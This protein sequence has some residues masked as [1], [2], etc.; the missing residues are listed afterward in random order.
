M[1]EKISNQKYNTID[2][3]S[4]KEVIERGR[5]LDQAVGKKVLEATKEQKLEIE[6]NEK[7]SVDEIAKIYAPCKVFPGSNPNKVNVSLYGKYMP[8]MTVVMPTKWDKHVKGD[9]YVESKDVTLESPLKYR[10]IP[11]ITDSLGIDYNAKVDGVVPVKFWKSKAG[12]PC[13]EVLQG[14]DI[15]KTTHMLIKAH[16]EKRFGYGNEYLD[17]KYGTFD[18]IGYAAGWSGKITPEWKEKG[19]KS[20]MERAGLSYFHHASSNG[21]AVGSDYYVVPVD[22]HAEEWDGKPHHKDNELAIERRQKLRQAYEAEREKFRG[23]VLTKMERERKSAEGMEKY[24]PVFEEL[25]ERLNS[26]L[27]EYNKEAEA[28]GWSRMAAMEMGIENSQAKLH[29]E[30]YAFDENG[31][32]ELTERV[33]DIVDYIDELRKENSG[34]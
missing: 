15:N 25:Q 26:T 27:L 32:K 16:Y 11:E 29:R 17:E 9:E 24:M 22:Y 21:G 34:L 12:K 31:M 7:L 23:K 6:E 2:D 33:N 19:K 13:C 4:E 20:P 18:E 3:A 30:Y 14:D 5:K 1:S 8:N 28:N 10:Q